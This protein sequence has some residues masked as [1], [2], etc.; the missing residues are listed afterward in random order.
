MGY[1]YTAISGF[2]LDSILE[3]LQHTKD[4]ANTSNGWKHKGVDYFYEQGRE[5]D[6][7][8]ITGSV[9]K[10]LLVTQPCTICIKPECS[11]HCRKVGSVKIDSK[12]NVVRFATSSQAQRLAA[13]VDADKMYEETY[14]RQISPAASG[15]YYT[16]DP[17]FPEK[18]SGK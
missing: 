12:G 4:A 11:G 13:K 8:S 7:G 2:A 10:N 14:N 15:N 9:W 16:G 17:L 18:I 6:D 5:Q 3:Q 1:S